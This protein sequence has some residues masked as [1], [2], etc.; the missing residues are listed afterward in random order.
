MQSSNPIKSIS[1]NFPFLIFILTLMVAFWSLMCQKEY[2]F[3]NE[4]VEMV[5]LNIEI[6]DDSKMIIDENMVEIE[7]LSEFLKQKVNE[8]DKKGIS[9]D[10]VL[11][12]ISSNGKTTLGSISDVQEQMRNFNIRMVSYQKNLAY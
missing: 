8:L 10:R 6:L 5:S 3:K 2:S 9:R 1:K 11:C 4:D 12:S 7:D